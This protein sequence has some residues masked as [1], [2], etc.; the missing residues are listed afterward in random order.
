ML[1]SGYFLGSK[2]GELSQTQEGASAKQ[3]TTVFG[4]VLKVVL[5]ETV[6]LLDA[7]G[8][9]LPVGSI[10]Y[11]DITAE[12]ETSTTEHSALPLI[13][14]IKQLPLINEI[15]VITPGPTSQI[16]ENVTDSIMYYGTVVNIWGNVNHNAVPEPNTDISTILGKDT[17]ELSD[18]NPLYPFPGDL[19]IEARQGQSIRMGGYMSQQNIMVDSSNNGSPFI[20]ISNGQIKTDNGIDHI[21][22]DV[23]KDPNS[24]YFLSNHKTGLKAANTKRDA[25]SKV[26]QASDQYKGN[27]VVLNGGR[28]YFN[29]KDESILL[30]AKESVGINAKTVNL[31]AT[32]YFC[33]DSKKIYLGAKARTGQTENAVLG[34]QL[35]NWLQSLVSNL[36]V[37][38]NAMKVATNGGGSIASLQ[39]AGTALDTTLHSLQLQISSIKSNKVYI[40]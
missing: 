8:R 40:E 11:R 38:A 32:E 34:T 1:A 26:P 9:R 3:P 21:V 12:K 30:S 35:D 28:L 16:Q 18:I 25:Y 10:I 37:I 22:E 14:N 31:D 5:D 23:N 2:I 29:A 15:V 20:L 36:Q 39:A 7:K 24:L 17:Q 33:V 13:L 27:Q 6:E 19:L 4:R